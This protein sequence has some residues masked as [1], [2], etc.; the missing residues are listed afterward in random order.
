MTSLTVIVGDG[1]DEKLGL[2]ELMGFSMPPCTTSC[3]TP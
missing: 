3:E 1:T 2:T